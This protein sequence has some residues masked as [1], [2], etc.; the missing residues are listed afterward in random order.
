MWLL[1]CF[2]LMLGVLV[3]DSRSHLGFRGASMGLFF[4][5]SG[6]SFLLGVSTWL[7]GVRVCCL[8]C[9]LVGV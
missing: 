6:V 1:D 5:L 7:F 2:T 8:C 3:A 4:C 9:D